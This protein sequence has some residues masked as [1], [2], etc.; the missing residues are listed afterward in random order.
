M[1]LTWKGPLPEDDPIFTGGVH[2]VFK[3]PLDPENDEEVTDNS[4]FAHG[5]QALDSDDSND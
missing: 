5:Q 3:R 1:P 4:A 2:F